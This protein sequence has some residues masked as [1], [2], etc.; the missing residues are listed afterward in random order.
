MTTLHKWWWVSLPVMLLLSASAVAAEG[1]WSWPFWNPFKSEKSKSKKV[2]ASVTDQNRSSFQLPK[3]PEL[4][5]PSLPSFTTKRTSAARRSAPSHSP[6][7]WDKMTQGTKDFFSKTYDVLTPWDNHKSAPAKPPTQLG[8]TSRPS[9]SKGS[10]WFSW[11]KSDEPKEP[12]TV[13]EFIAQP[14]V[15]P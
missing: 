4:P 5:K 10:S 11:P 8:G 14:R 15:T 2:T 13:N 9:K 12:R 6:S 3:L 1:S 7:M